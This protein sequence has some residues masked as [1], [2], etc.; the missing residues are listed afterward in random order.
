MIENSDMLRLCEDPWLSI[1]SCFSI[2]G[3]FWGDAVRKEFDTAEEGVGRRAPV[4][5][6]RLI[7]AA[8]TGVAPPDVADAGIVSGVLLDLELSL[9]G[10]GD[11]LRSVAGDLGG[12]WG[13]N[14]GFTV[15]T[16]SDGFMPGLRIGKSGLAPA[17]G[18]PCAMVGV[19]CCA[20]TGEG[21]VTQEIIASPNGPALQFVPGAL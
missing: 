17:L 7:S 1:G 21:P 8:L 20:S 13:G 12:T 3:E 5:G 6:E 11:P 18:D 10:A 4:L 2:R 9:R 16:F 19:I 14:A 15:S